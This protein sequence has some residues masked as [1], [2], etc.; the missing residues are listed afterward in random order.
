MVPMPWWIS[1]GSQSQHFWVV[2]SEKVSRSS[3][4]IALQDS[5]TTRVGNFVLDKFIVA[6]IGRSGSQS[7]KTND[8]QR[9]KL[10]KILHLVLCEC[11]S[12]W[13]LIGVEEQVLGGEFG[14]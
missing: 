7:R 8:K 11:V 12:R 5:P 4:R 3:Y 6:F 14:K 9:E 1:D 13:I 10:G 2:K